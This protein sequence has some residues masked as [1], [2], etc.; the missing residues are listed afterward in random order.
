M[1]RN[2]KQTRMA[3]LR[4]ESMRDE[5]SAMRIDSNLKTSAGLGLDLCL[6]SFE[7]RI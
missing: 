5:Q 4:Y 1:F 6:R 2:Y 3:A 7:V